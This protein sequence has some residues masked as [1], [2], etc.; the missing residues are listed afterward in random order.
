MSWRSHAENSNT[1]WNHR[2][3]ED[4]IFVVSGGRTGGDKFVASDVSLSAAALRF[5]SWRAEDPMPVARPMHKEYVFA[6][7][8][9]LATCAGC[10]GT[11]ATNT[12][13]VGGTSSNGGTNAGG[14]LR[15]GASAVGGS[16]SSGM[17]STAGAV[18][19]GTMS[20]VGAAT[21]GGS[22]STGGMPTT[23]F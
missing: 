7:G 2:R 12:A 1:T 11:H 3:C 18:A 21:Q 16:T 4:D 5:Q 22:S 20:S 6:A 9:L 23:G 15:G 13:N 19:T 8:V 17:S 14:A 10:S